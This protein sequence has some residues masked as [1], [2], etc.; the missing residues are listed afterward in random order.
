[1]LGTR[2]LSESTENET[3]TL[4][5]FLEKQRELELEAAAALPFKFDKC[6]AELG[7]LRQNLHICHGCPNLKGQDDRQMAFCYACAVTCHNFD[8]ENNCFDKGS[9]RKE[10]DD[11]FDAYGDESSGRNS[12]SAPSASHTIE[13]IWARRNFICDCPSTGHCKLLSK[14]PEAYAFHTN[15][16]HRPHNFY[17]RYC[18]CD[19]K[20][21]EAGDRT[22]F[23]CEIC[24]DWYHDTCVAKDHQNLETEQ[25]EIPD[26]ETFSDFICKGCVTRHHSALFSKISLND[27]IFTVPA[28]DSLKSSPAP[29]FLV[30]GWRDILRLQCSNVVPVGLEHL[31]REEEL[32]YEPEID[33][34]ANES[35]YDRK[36]NQIKGLPPFYPSFF[37]SV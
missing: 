35:L 26:E 12:P 33:A 11:V 2:E 32:V 13:E 25:L 7:P 28:R 1:M 10:V 4:K 27:T 3:I 23:Q 22:M 8:P 24:E 37:F 19:G 29:L 21:W 14:V 6:S 17:G 36:Q 9:K 5:E 20:G 31:L 15:S 18:F 34:D 30:K 16:Y